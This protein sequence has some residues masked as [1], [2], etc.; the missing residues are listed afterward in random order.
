[1]WFTSDTH[2]GHSNIITLSA[3]PFSSIEEM[4]EGLISR[5]NECVKTSDVVYHL[6][7]FSFRPAS[8]FR[9][10]LN[11]RICLIRGNHDKDKLLKDAGFEWIKDAYNARGDTERSIGARFWLSH[12][13]HRAWPQS[14]KGSFHLH[15]HSHGNM[16][17]LGRSMDVGVD[18]EGRYRPWHIDEVIDVLKDATTT[19]HHPKEM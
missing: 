18:V 2:F 9:R 3:R 13:P 1:M 15:G 4:N 6:G 10:K 5:W 14:H 7:D 11:G 12:Y 19:E 16:P 8:Q 17:R